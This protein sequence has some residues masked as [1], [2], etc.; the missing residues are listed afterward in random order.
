M[1]EL[2]GTS[3]ST[4]LN[5][6]SGSK[7][8]LLGTSRTNR[9][10]ARNPHKR[11]VSTG[12]DGNQATRMFADEQPGFDVFFLFAKSGIDQISNGGL[13]TFSVGHGANGLVISLVLTSVLP[14]STSSLAPRGAC[15]SHEQP[16][17][18]G[19][20]RTTLVT[21]RFEL[22]LTAYDESSLTVGSSCLHER[23]SPS[24]TR[25]REALLKRRVAAMFVELNLLG[26][27]ADNPVTR[28]AI[29][30]RVCHGKCNRRRSIFDP[31]SESIKSRGWVAIADA[32]RQPRD[33]KIPEEV[34]DLAVQ[35]FHFVVVLL[36][37]IR[38]D[39]LVHLSRRVST[40]E[41]WGVWAADIQVR[42]R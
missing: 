15:L 35:T 12:C 20:T 13:P 19:D 30:Q 21:M 1:P 36:H 28:R 42:G 38:R 5:N 37:Y 2:L 33:L 4:F 23:P 14:S 18:D 7:P 8:I 24:L 31:C 22:K 25:A 27:R 29:H 16:N 6:F 32:M 9:A 17:S 39:R 10:E 34:L 3:L 40:N 11:R 41:R 26:I